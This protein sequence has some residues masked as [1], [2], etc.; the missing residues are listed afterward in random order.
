MVRF[1]MAENANSFLAFKQSGHAESTQVAYNGVWRL[2]C[3]YLTTLEVQGGRREAG[4]YLTNV[5]GA[6]DK[7]YTW[8]DFVYRLR[9]KKGVPLQ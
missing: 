5:E 3:E 2:W 7:C 9:G 6:T 1:T 8:E 4:H